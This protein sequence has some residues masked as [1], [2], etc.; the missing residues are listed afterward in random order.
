MNTFNQKNSL[1]VNY[2]PLMPFKQLHCEKQSEKSLGR[3]LP[4]VTR[5]GRIASRGQGE[6]E[7]L[8]ESG[9][10]ASRG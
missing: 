2:M 6:G 7:G 4:G 9:R 8:I 5:H 10:I 3:D 1:Y